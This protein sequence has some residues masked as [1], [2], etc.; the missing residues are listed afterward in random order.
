[1]SDPTKTLDVDLAN[2]LALRPKEAAERLGELQ[3]EALDLAG[4]GFV[5]WHRIQA[6]RATLRDD[7]RTRP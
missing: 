4:W 1:M 2:R 7:R 5:L 3:E 6:M